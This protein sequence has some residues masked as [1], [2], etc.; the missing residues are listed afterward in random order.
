[1]KVYQ[2]NA[3]LSDWHNLIYTMLK[4]CSPVNYRQFL[5]IKKNIEPEVLLHDLFMCS[6]CSKIY[7]IHTGF[8]TSRSTQNQ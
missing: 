4:V 2:C 1:M 7:T 8:N 3:V 5:D 6:L